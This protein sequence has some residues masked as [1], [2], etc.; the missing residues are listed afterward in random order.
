MEKGDLLSFA[1]ATSNPKQLITPDPTSQKS[2]WESERIEPSFGA[3]MGSGRKDPPG[4]DS[5]MNKKSLQKYT[6]F[7]GTQTMKKPPMG[8]SSMDTPGYRISAY[9]ENLSKEKE[10]KCSI[11]HSRN[12]R[13]NKMTPDQHFHSKNA[14]T[15]TTERKIRFPESSQQWAPFQKERETQ[16]SSENSNK[17]ENSPVYHGDSSRV[18]KD[19]IWWLKEK[20]R[21]SSEDIAKTTPR[22]TLHN[23]DQISVVLDV[24]FLRE[25]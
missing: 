20:L 10:N 5:R 19:I 9:M 25:D 8:T 23:L 14:T 16:K 13:R 12:A 4:I 24:D 1:R 15:M 7:G 21:I 6:S 11:N 2:P 17:G 18:S 3:T 22:S